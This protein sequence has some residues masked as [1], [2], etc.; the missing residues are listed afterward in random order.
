MKLLLKGF[1]F[2]LILNTL[3]LILYTPQVQAQDFRT[4]YQVEYFLSENQN[5]LNTRVMFTITI[6]NFRSDAYVKQFSIGFPKSF[7]IKDVKAFD[8]YEEIT[9][10]VSFSDSITNVA[11][12]FSRLNAGK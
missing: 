12:E 10:K 1:L 2:F 11:L 8:D 3:Y 7:T 6:T 4:D 9:P 5:K